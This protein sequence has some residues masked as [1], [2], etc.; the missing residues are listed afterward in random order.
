MTLVEP[1]PAPD[2]LCVAGPEGRFTN[3]I[4]VPLVREV[5]APSG[6][7]AAPAPRAR[8]AAAGRGVVRAYPPGSEWLFAKLYCGRGSGDIVLR[9]IVAPMIERAR[10]TLSLGGWFFL[11]YADPDTHIRIRFN[12]DRAVIPQVMG[13][14]AALTTPAVASGRLARVVYDT[15]LPEIER[16][17]GPEAI[18]VAEALFAVDSDAALAVITA[19]DAAPALRDLR[20]SA[21]RL[22]A[23]AGV[24]RLL[25]DAG[26]ETEARIALLGR[27]LMGVPAP[28]RHERGAQFRQQRAS[29]EAALADVGDAASSSALATLLR[30][31]TARMRPMLGRLRALEAEGVLVATLDNIVISLAHMW[32]NRMLSDATAAEATLYDHLERAYRSAAGRARGAGRS[33]AADAVPEPVG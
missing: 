26:Y 33:H 18:G 23:L 2:A 11:R 10:S 3:E 21:R 22:V 30:E 14:L 24:D 7:P 31:R 13:E 1:F 32:V 29:I 27:T 16:S 15:Y 5:A 12:A 17:G 28:V 9:E 19:G 4:V 25:V 6:A 20:E 8:G